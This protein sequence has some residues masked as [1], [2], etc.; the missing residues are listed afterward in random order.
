MPP[1]PLPFVSDGK[2]FLDA[3]APIGFSG[4]LLTVKSIDVK[5]NQS[6]EVVT[7]IGVKRGAG[8]RKKKGGFEIDLT[9]FRT[10][11]ADPEV[12]W[13]LA[14]DQDVFMTLTTQDE[15]GGR[16]RAYTIQVSKTDSK[17][18]DQGMCEDT[19]TLVATQRY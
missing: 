7:T 17:T 11:G 6:R 18:D 12:D 19:I 5:D 10:I 3:P 9:E 13:D 2:I 16:R 15:G 8:T 14:N 1:A 4:Q